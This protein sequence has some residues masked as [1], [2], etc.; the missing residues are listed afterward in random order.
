VI[1]FGA[2]GAVAFEVIAF[3]I[4]FLVLGIIGSLPGGVL[5]AFVDIPETPGAYAS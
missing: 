5:Y 3:S 2:S 1:L 4:L